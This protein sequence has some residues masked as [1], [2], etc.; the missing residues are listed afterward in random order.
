MVI[1][2]DNPTLTCVD[3]SR[4]MSGIIGTV[5]FAR[6][7]LC[8]LINTPIVPT[9]VS[10]E[11]IVGIGPTHQELLS[12]NHCQHSDVIITVLA[13]LPLHQAEVP[14]PVLGLPADPL[15]QVLREVGEGEIVDNV[16]GSDQE[17][18]T[19]LSE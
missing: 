15:L 18:R 6:V 4:I 12:V 14:V 10:T 1:M 17:G 13:R 3:G 11:R 8:H 19:V 5:T 16:P 2:I 7:L 9:V